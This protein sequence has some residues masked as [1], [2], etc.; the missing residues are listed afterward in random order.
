M[1]LI[2]EL[3]HAI[4]LQ[5]STALGAE[6]TRQFTVMSYNRHATIGQEPS[7]TMLYDVATIQHIYG[8]DMTTRTGSDTYTL[9]QVN[10]RV[11]TVWDAGGNDTFDFSGA[12]VAVTIDLREG[13]YSTVASSGRN[14]VAIAFGTVIENAKGG[15]GN[16]LIVSNGADNVLAGGAGADIFRFHLGWGNDTVADFARGQDRLDLSATGL[17]F[18]DLAFSQ[19]AEGIRVAHAEESVVLAGVF[20]LDQSDFLFGA[21]A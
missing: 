1:L 8:K 11:M 9:A 17:A 18:A 15:A 6:D 5:H 20:A 7:T 10:N 19:Q 4:G 2:H 21:V 14:N 12:A 3:G 16:D 13:T